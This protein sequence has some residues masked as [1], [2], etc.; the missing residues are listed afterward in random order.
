MMSRLGRFK[1]RLRYP[2]KKIF[3]AG[4]QHYCPVCKSHIRLLQEA[5]V[6]RRQN[7]KCPVCGALERHRLA[8][9]VLE[10]KTN[11][12]DRQAKKI[13]HVAPEHYLKHRFLK[14]AYLDYTTTDL[15]GN[16]VNLNMDITAMS[17]PDN[18]F[19]VVYCSHVLEHVVDDQQAMRE[20]WRVLKPNGW[21]ALDVPITVEVTIE[22]PS[23]TDPAERKRL[24]GQEDH[25]R[26]YGKDYSEQLTKAGFIVRQFIAAELVGNANLH[27]FG[28]E[29]NRRCF[30]GSKP[31]TF[32]QKLP[33][34]AAR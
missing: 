29:A 9:L 16:H 31:D 6:I 11:L 24:F 30:I 18:T 26:R 28:L 19:D 32:A 2:L 7:A 21:A 8:W 23:I 17:F 12:L 10:K 3:Y 1:S 14:L 13:L 33:P 20:I 34:V 5:G 4:T 15:V 25:V 22:D 27:H